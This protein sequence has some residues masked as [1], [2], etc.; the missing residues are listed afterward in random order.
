[1]PALVRN[2][3]IVTVPWRYPIRR[4][5]ASNATFDSGRR[6]LRTLGKHRVRTV[7]RLNLPMDRLKVATNKS[8]LIHLFLAS[9]SPTYDLPFCNWPF[10]LFRYNEPRYQLRSTLSTIWTNQ[11]LPPHVP[12]SNSNCQRASRRA[13]PKLHLR[14]R[15]VNSAKNLALRGRMN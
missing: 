10:K 3:C 4:S 14:A 5:A 15:K 11:I 6:E 8:D 9:G 1:V 7:R 2:P 13:S 12:P